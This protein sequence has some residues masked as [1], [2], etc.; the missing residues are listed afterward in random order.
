MSEKSSIF[1]A[2]VRQDRNG[3]WVKHLL[4]EH[5]RGVASLA[6]SFAAAFEAGDWA[7]LAGLWHDLGKYREAFQHYICSASGYDA[8]IETAPGK[9]DHSTAGALH[10]MDRMKGSGRILA[11]LIAGHHAGLPDWQSAEAPASSL[12]NRLSQADL[13]ADALAAEPPADI[14]NAPLPVSHPGGERDHALWIRLLFSCLVDADFLDTEQFMTPDKAGLR[15][16][17]PTLADLEPR[18]DAH[19]AGLA[20]RASDTPVNRMRAAVLERCRN[21]AGQS[22][23]LFSL[24]VPTGGGKTLASL[25]FALRHA[26]QHGKRRIL[27]VIPYTS[28]IEQTADVFRAVFGADAVLEHHS[29]FEADRETPSSRLACEN[30]DAPLIVTTSVQFFESLFANRPSRTRK[31]HNILDSVVILDEAQLL[32]PDFLT[33]ILRTVR[34]LSRYYGVSFVLCTATQPDLSSRHSF[35][36]S[37]KGLDDVREIVGDAAAVRELHDSLRRVKLTLPTDFQTSIT[38]EALAAE[39]EDHPRVLCIVD[40]RDDA[41]ILHGLLP[42]DTVHLSGLMCGQHRSDVIAGIKKRLE[43]SDEPLRVISTQLVEAGVDLDFPAVYRA[44]AGLD[45]IAQAAGRCNR[46]GR[47]FNF[48]Q[49]VVFVPPTQPPAGHLR[50]ACQAG[51]QILQR[52]PPD[53]LAPALFAEYFQS[54]YWQKGAEQLDGKGILPLLKNNQRLEFSFRTAAERFQLIP[55]IQAPVIVRYGDNEPL[56]AQLTRSSDGLERKLLRQLQRYVVNIPRRVHRVLLTD[57]AIIE[58]Q[59]GIFIQV[60]PLYDSVLGLR[61]D[62]TQ[63]ARY[64]PDDLIA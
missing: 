33:P 42:P 16:C 53:P 55:E 63:T 12:I 13:L 26:R 59:P 5:L 51:R 23:G 57:G 19:M 15:G 3:Q 37:L 52:R 58:R 35:D 29:L 30:W 6:E 4:D 17:Y 46:E 11:Y 7:R 62:D 9:V 8:H 38:W 50:Q 40:R 43:N 27:Y 21:T 34:E 39:L 18:Y 44:L 61:V 60:A 54:L 14:L 36:F 24:T 10:A 32:P 64:S 47:L 1:L 22:P 25:A 31:L 49:V 20:E 41:R 48:G 45:S 28:I 56:L 2:H